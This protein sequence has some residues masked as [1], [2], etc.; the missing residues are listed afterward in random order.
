MSSSVPAAVVLAGAHGG[1]G[2]SAFLKGLS[3]VY[4]SEHLFY[5]PQKTSFPFFGLE[6]A[7]VA[8]LD[9][10]RFEPS[11]IPFATQCLWF[12]GSP[13][14]VARPQN[15]AH[16]IGHSLCRGSAPIFITTKLQDLNRL[17]GLAAPA[18]AAGQPADGD[19]SMVLRRL[20]VYT[21]N[22]RVPAPAKELPTCARC[23]AQ[24]VSAQ[25]RDT[26]A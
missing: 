18:R 24:C 25:A 9:D 12:D 13:L 26:S 11:V 5:A 3:A 6:H 10:C 1:E 23:F 22:T 20:Q 17:R 2:K 14:P 8:L 7:K 16:A 4:G 21:F 19:A 15:Q